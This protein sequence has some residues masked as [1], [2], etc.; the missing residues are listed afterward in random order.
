[1]LTNVPSR[2]ISSRMMLSLL[3][4]DVRSHIFGFDPTFHHFLR[5]RVLPE[6]R[7]FRCRRVA[8][9]LRIEEPIEFILDNMFSFYRHDERHTVV[10][11]D[12]IIKVC[13]EKS[14]TVQ[15]NFCPA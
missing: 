8:S 3:P 15:T 1:M 5:E 10:F 9:H 14:G 2:S 11:V 12:S 13:H 4:G 6:I 7:F